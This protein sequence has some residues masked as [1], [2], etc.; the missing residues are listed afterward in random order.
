MDL[1]KKGLSQRVLIINVYITQGILLAI[2]LLGMYFFYLRRGITLTALFSIENLQPSLLSGAA[3]AGAVVMVEAV[4]ISVFPPETFDDGGLNELL[5][6]GLPY[7]HIAFI[8]FAVAFCEELL[9]R[10]IMQSNLGLW[11][12]SAVFALIHV[13]Y[14]KKWVMFLTVLLVSLLL[15]WLL[16]RTGSLWSVIAAHFL[17]DFI[18][19]C[20]SRNGWF[21]PKKE[22][23]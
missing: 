5:F 22:G 1:E 15:G 4:M 11:I 9:F 19:G 21:I 8:A 16:N 17:I 3:A 14:L 18:L 7:W 10:G 12:T 13:R 6:K 2:G 20:F 23:F